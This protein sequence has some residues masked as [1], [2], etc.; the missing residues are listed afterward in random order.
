MHEGHMKYGVLP[1]LVYKLQ[2]TGIKH[3]IQFGISMGSANVSVSLYNKLIFLIGFLNSD[4]DV[5]V[6]IQ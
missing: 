4:A 3:N 5:V 2:L 1:S 6:G